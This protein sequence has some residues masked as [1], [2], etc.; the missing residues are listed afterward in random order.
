MISVVIATDESEQLLVPTLAALVPGA[1]AGL[2]RDVIIADAGSRDGTAAVADVAGCRFEVMPGPLGARLKAAAQL[3]RAPWLM[4]LRPGSVPGVTWVEEI[5]RLVRDAG[6]GVGQDIRAAVF[7]RAPAGG[8]ARPIVMEALTLL[9][10]AFGGRPGPDQGLLI[11]KKFYD[12]IGGHRVDGGDPEAD[13]LRRLGRR[14][15][16]LLRNGVAMSR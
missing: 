16:V 10:T 3:A 15:I 7:R 5:G 6:L 14:R 1:M 8:R 2:V 13:L 4:F 11:S 12:T 9:A